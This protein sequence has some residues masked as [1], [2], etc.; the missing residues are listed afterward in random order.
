MKSHE[1]HCPSCGSADTIR[2]RLRSVDDDEE[3]ARAD[4]EPVET[5]KWSCLRCDHSFMPYSCPECGSFEIDGAR[6]VS[7]APYLK[8]RL[9]VACRRCQAEFPAHTSVVDHRSVNE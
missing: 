4:A 8:P 2:E 5:E 3:H 1:V 7:A 6:G 9:V